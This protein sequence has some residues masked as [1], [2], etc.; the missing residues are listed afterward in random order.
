VKNI[1]KAYKGN[2]LKQISVVSAITVPI[3]M[4]A[5]FAFVVPYGNEFKH[6]KKESLKLERELRIVEME[7]DNKLSQKRNIETENRELLSQLRTP[8]PI[9]KF[10]DE[11]L[12]VENAILKNSLS[13]KDGDLEKIVYQISTRQLQTTLQNFYDLIE[14]T[15]SF[16]F[17]FQVGFPI[18][19]EAEKGKVASTFF[20][21]LY[22][23]PPFKQNI[24]RPFTEI[25]K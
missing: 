15:G 5:I 12:F 6:Q 22:K 24:V 8:K 18:E 14:E 19:F 9:I 10:L 13:G 11:N 7:R 3:L 2:Y 17:R 21:D 16:G 1:S 20:V 4:I 23:L 25:Q